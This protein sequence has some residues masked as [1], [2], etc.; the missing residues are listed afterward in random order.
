MLRHPHLSVASLLGAA[1]LAEIAYGQP[2]PPT[3]HRTGLVAQGEPGRRAKYVPDQ[4]LVRFRP[5]V[6]KLAMRAE[7]AWVGAEVLREFRVVSNLHLIRLP[8]GTPVKQ[9]ARY[10]RE[11]PDVLYAEPNYIRHADQPPVTPND[12][13]FAE[14]WNLHNT[15]QSGGTPGADIHAPEAWSLATGSAN[16][17]VGVID[18]G[19]DYSHVDLSANM[20]RNSADCNSN[21]IDDDGNGYKDDCYGIDTANGDSSPMDDAGHGT[22]V[23]GTIGARGN[24]GIGVVGVNWSVQLMACKFLDSQGSGS[25]SDAITC[26]EYMAMMKD[27]GVNLVATNNSW[28]GGGFSQALLDAIDA[29]RQRGILF[30]AAAGNSRANT[31]LYSFYPANY[32]LPNIIA[33]AA[34]DRSDA[35]ASFSNFGRH[36]VHLG[37]PGVEILSTVPGSLSADLYLRASGT[38]MA[39][40][41]VTGV[42]ALLAA[43]DP[44]RDW[45]AIRNL[46]LAGGETI[47]SVAD[48][49]TQKRLNAHG[50]LTCSNSV[51]Q[52]RLL[53]M[54]DDAYVSAGDSLTFKMLN[55]NCAAPNGPVQVPVDGGATTITLADD[56]LGPDIEANDGIYVAQRQWFDSEIGRHTLVF[57][58]NDVVTVH[59]VPPLAPYTFSTGIPF[60]YRQIEGT[61]LE[62]RDDD[63]MLIRPPF[64]VQFSGASFP[65]LYVNSNGNVTF[66]EPFVE[67][68]NSPLPATGAPVLIAP[69]WD[70]VFADRYYGQSPSVRWDVTG[71]AP[72]RELVIEWRDV[73]HMR[74][75]GN[76]LMTAKFQI[77]FF[78]G[79]SDI[80]F[81]YADVIFGSYLYG[82][83]WCQ[84]RLA[85]INAGA[86]ATVG[87]QSMSNLANQFSF[88]AR[89]LT[90]NSSILWQIGDITPSITQ[91]SP[92]SAL[93]GAPGVSLQ[94]LGRS[95]LPG[96]V[97]RW[98]GSDRP[99]TFVHGGELTATI[100]ASDLAAPGTAQVTVF[101]P[102]PNSTGE[103]APAPFDIYSSNPVPTLTGVVP[104]TVVLDSLD[105]G[106]PV[107]LTGTGFVSN[108]VARCNGADRATAAVSSTEL[109][110]TPLISD[111]TPGGTAQVTVFNPGP[112]GGTSNALPLNFANPAPTLIDVR[113]RFVGAGSPAFTLWMAGRDLM[114]TSVV[115]WNGSDRPTSHLEDDFSWLTAAIPATDVA[116]IGTAQV[117]VFTPTPGGGT[118]DPVTI[119][120]VAPPGNDSFANATVV[121]TYPFTGTQ[122]ARGA[123]RESVD[124]QPP[125]QFSPREPQESV[126][127]RF[128]PPAAG[129]MINADAIGSNYANVPVLSAWTG[130]PGN[131]NNL[132]CSWFDADVR[133]DPLR[134]VTTSTSPIY[135]MVNSAFMGD[136]D[137]LVFNLNIRPW[138]TLEPS[139]TSKSVPRGSTA[140]YTVTVTPHFGSFNDPIALTCRVVPAGPTCSL[141]PDSVTPGGAPAPV[142]LT[143]ATTTM[144]QLVRPDVPAPLFAFWLALPAI[145]LLAARRNLPGTRKI[146]FHLFLALVL[147]AAMLGMQTACGG[148]GDTPSP[149]QTQTFT[150]TVTG[151]SGTISQ[152]TSTRLFVTP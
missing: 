107:T 123:T 10:Y 45:K 17:V 7:H 104:E 4:L 101:D 64:P 102:P 94:V 2:G 40:P 28:G 135:F 83:F 55:I 131:F 3:G 113:P 44:T 103:S 137:T 108:S 151:T 140:T 81:N 126:W 63:S 111:L 127:F 5:T 148:G 143:V 88:N 118:S 26:L 87:V 139:P 32:D 92:F 11:R 15:G 152:Q 116:S 78:E 149:P 34:T 16:V 130:S 105:P 23:A 67:W 76:P 51:V 27:R 89:S 112:G 47:P 96:A 125:C 53:P 129:V 13:R 35:L 136:A 65:T 62:L 39:A 90:D 22:H 46:I 57:P 99:T 14:M 97:V 147:I 91:L 100:P 12:P 18:T 71:A 37:A 43:Q 84:E 82:G 20:F 128:T 72:N 122:S 41:H 133:P 146:R 86:S 93:A 120:I 50:A 98:N 38:S 124:P 31:D 85:S 134:F 9:A 121:S 119:S 42:A 19:I 110:M 69:F 142:T 59:V 30:I 1:L 117:T 114:P 56:G 52:L 80:L 60:N 95:F 61:D 77:V 54:A 73:V 48:T 79:S 29:H 141:S 24:N 25:D 145:G 8:A 74:C 144:A 68:D 58:N 75:L 49:I 138:F 36:K 21:G 106:K 66:F 115:R 109:R 70:D 150:I 6:S 132:G 33:V